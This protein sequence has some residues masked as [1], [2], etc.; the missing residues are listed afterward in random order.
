MS[1]LAKSWRKLQETV[2]AQIKAEEMPKLLLDEAIVH[3]TGQ[4]VQ[5]VP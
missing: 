2:G 1:Y 3:Q 5:L 4:R